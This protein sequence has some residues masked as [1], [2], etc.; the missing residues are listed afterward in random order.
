MAALDAVGGFESLGA[1]GRH[2]PL[3]TPPP[4]STC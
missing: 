1:L 2:D 4:A 3:A